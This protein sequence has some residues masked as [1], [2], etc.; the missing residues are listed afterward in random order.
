[1]ARERPTGGFAL[2]VQLLQPRQVQVLVL[3]GVLANR[4]ASR[5]FTTTQI[6]KLYSDLRLPPPAN[7]SDNVAKLRA[8]D[9]VI[10]DP[11]SETRAL[12]P[13][14]EAEALKRLEEL[15]YEQMAAELIGSP[16]AQLGSVTHPLIGPEFAPP[17]WSAGIA[18]LLERF[19]FDNN[20]FC[21]T[22][23]PSEDPQH[24][25]T[26]LLAHVVTEVRA[27]AKQHG[28][29]VHLASD[30]QLEDDLLGNVAAYLWASKYGIG[31][32]ED[33]VNRGLNYNAVIEVGAMLVTGRRCAILRDSSAPALPTDLT[34]Q[35]YK[36]VDFAQLDTVQAATHHWLAEDLGLGRCRGCP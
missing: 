31:L 11:T 22:R 30:R 10:R 9:F 20:I 32:V 21:M 4:D 27:A 35:I 17:R 29:T 36:S 19:P 34:A 1:V 23:F 5:R 15:D 16:G 26:D 28:M 13:L 6:S 3:A 8:Q 24:K 25:A 18:R 2:K 33:R 14:G 12:T 7:V